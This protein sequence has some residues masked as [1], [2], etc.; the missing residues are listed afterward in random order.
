MR[1][2]WALGLLSAA[3]GPAVAGTPSPEWSLTTGRVTV[4]ALRFAD[5]NGDG[6]GEIILATMG[7]IGTPFSSGSVHVLDMSGNNLSGWP[8][9]LGNNL[10]IAGASVAVGDID[11]NGDMELV[12]EGWFRLHVWNH[13]GT[14]FPGWPKALATTLTASPALADLDG[15]GDLEIIAPDGSLMHVWQ[16]TGAEAAGWPQAA[17][18][19]FQAASVAD[20]DGDGQLEI[21]AGTWRVNFP[22][23]VPFQLYMWDAG[24]TVPAG[25]PINGLGSVRGPVSLGDIDADGQIEIVVRAGDSLHVFDASG[26]TMSGWPVIPGAIR[27]STPSLGDLDGDRDLEI[28][29]GSFDVH[30]YHHDGTPVAGWPVDPGSTGNINSGIVLASIDSDPATSEVIVKIPDQIVALDA[31]G[32]PVAGFP[33]SL[34]DDN[35]TAT[36]SPTP[37]AGDLD[38]DG[39]VEYAFVS[40]SGTLAFF[41]EP[42]PHGQHTA[43]WPQFQHDVYNTSYLAKGCP[44]DCGDR[45]GVVGVVDFLALLGQWGGPGPCDLDGGG[46]GITDFLELLTRWG[47]CG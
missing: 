12:V 31:S 15:D 43:F 28:L 13:D 46:V 3:A 21:V 9:L 26:Q 14:T 8:V 1:T 4:S 47:A 32:G 23:T 40:V 2:C 6:A 38:G 42:E 10:P 44:S 29:I 16:H 5:V 45:D 30:A 36:Y 33:Y 39:D 24:G 41:D 37:A 17:A 35:Q 27:S 7:P 22:D 25:F 11:D 20:V 18:E 34:S 19:S